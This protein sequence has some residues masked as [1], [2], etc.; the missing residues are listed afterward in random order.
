[1]AEPIV[2]YDVPRAT[3]EGVDAAERAFSGNTWRTRYV[4]N[5]KNIA[6]R[7]VWLE[8]PDIAGALTQLGAEPSTKYNG[9]PTYTVPTITDPNT[10]RV[11]TDSQA[12]AE[13]L[14]A[15][16]PDPPLFPARTRA[17]QAGAVARIR[18]LQFAVLYPLV[19]HAHYEQCTPCAQPHVRTTREAFFGARLEDVAPHGSAARAA[20]LDK[21]R[22]ELDEMRGWIAAGGEDALFLTGSTPSFADVDL[23][24]TLLGAWKIER[25]DAESDVLQVIASAG[26]GHWVRFMEAFKQY[27]TVN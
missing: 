7:T 1:M 11:V 27:E 20:L 24:A 10:G 18:A 21:V 16:Y 14:D 8:Y 5:M 3:A 26:G 22:A 2:F 13:Y 19:V 9:V 23:A 25:G 6:H 17:L 15:R 12:I 4:L